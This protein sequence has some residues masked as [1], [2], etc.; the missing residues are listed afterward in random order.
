[1]GSGGAAL[2][3]QLPPF[4]TSDDGLAAE[5]E[6][7]AEATGDGLWR[8]PL[9]AGYAGAVDSEIADI[10][11]DPDGWAQAGS[12]TAALFLLRFAPDCAWLHFDIYAWNP[13]GRP[14]HAA[15]A[16]IQTVRA[17][18]HLLQGRYA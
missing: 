15:G 16:E 12:I 14:G 7:A 18:F 9:W 3:P 1:M 13:R 8:M 6:Q 4:Y 11:N 5:L 10:K 2:G 17:L